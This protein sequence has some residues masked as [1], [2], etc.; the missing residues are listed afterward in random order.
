M[1]N[2]F[3]LPLIFT[4]TICF[5]QPAVGRAQDSEKAV[6]AFEVYADRLTSSD[7]AKETGF[8]NPSQSVPVEANEA[9]QLDEIRRLYGAIAAPADLATLQAASSE[10]GFEELPFEFFVRMQ[11]RSAKAAETAFADMSKEGQPEAIGGKNYLRPPA[12]AKSTPKNMLMHLSAPDTIEVGTDG[13]ILSSDRNV[14][15]DNLA[16]AWPKMPKAAIR[17]GIDLDGAR[18]LID[19]G[20]RMAQDSGGAVPPPAAAVLNDTSVLRLGLDF[21][22]ENLLWLTATG[23]DGDA[24]TRVNGILGGLMAMGKGMG[25]QFLP[26]AGP[27]AQAPGQAILDSLATTVDGND[28]NITIP[29][30]EGLEKALEGAFGQLMMAGMGAGGME[31]GPGGMDA[32][33]GGMDAGGFGDGM[34]GMGDEMGGADAFGDAFGEPSGLDA[35]PEAD[36]FGDPAAEAA[37]AGGADPF[38]DL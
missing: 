2:T 3:A 16:A 10:Q 30:P 17:I 18:H 6:V 38:G 27:D 36:P 21:S 26:M 7:L 15:T 9:L 14:F 13:Y 32:G 35:M 19:E 8:D 31:M 11:Y 25:G 24:A 5:L 20:I 28:V 33:P 1:R 23:H 4:A 34:D 29:K 37:P 12:D 22:G